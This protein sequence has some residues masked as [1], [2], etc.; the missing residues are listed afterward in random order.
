MNQ[1]DPE[2]P[3]K[4]EV[5]KDPG[6]K[7]EKQQEP[8]EPIPEKEEDPL[9]RQTPEKEEEPFPAKEEEKQIEPHIPYEDQ[10]DPHNNPVEAH[11][12]VNPVK[13]PRV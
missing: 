8:S 13:E 1:N 7:P 5:Q 3:L 6:P 9:P 4:P 11:G 2:K 10:I 12:L